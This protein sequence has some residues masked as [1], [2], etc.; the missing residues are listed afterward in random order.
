MHRREGGGRQR[1]GGSGDSGSAPRPRRP[2]WRWRGCYPTFDGCAATHR[3][4]GRP[5]RLPHPPPHL[6]PCGARHGPA[7]GTPRRARRVRPNR[8]RGNR[9]GRGCRTVMT[10]RRVPA[11]RR[12]R[13]RAHRHGG[14]GANREEKKKKSTAGRGGRRRT[15]H[16]PPGPH[17]HTP[18]PRARPHP[19]CRRPVLSQ[20]HPSGAR[21]SERAPRGGGGAH[22]PTAIGKSGRPG[23]PPRRRCSRT[24][25]G[26]GG[27]A[28]RVGRSQQR[29][30]AW[31]TPPRR[32]APHHAT[33]LSRHVPPIARRCGVGSPPV[34][35][36]ATPHYSTVQYRPGWRW[37]RPG[38]HRGNRGCPP[39]PP[40]LQ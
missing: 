39:R 31:P 13:P 14:G 24:R 16:T 38:A 37:R 40:S 27:A 11:A 9:G 28:G 12:S 26:G 8:G 22:P 4:P 32:H 30:A 2:R 3:L 34:P 25:R 7:E 1:G 36:R 33:G 18:P 6:C 29:A 15:R 20:W 17:T 35:S 19:H 10:P 5:T 23:V 21:D